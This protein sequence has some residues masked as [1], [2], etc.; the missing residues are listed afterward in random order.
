MASVR[1]FCLIVNSKNLK[2]INKYFS[3]DFKPYEI[4]KII[5]GKKNVKFD[6]RINWEK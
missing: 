6:G 2:K 1:Y 3:K 5:N 4:G